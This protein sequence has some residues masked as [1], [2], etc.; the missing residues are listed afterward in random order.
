M[1]EWH[2]CPDAI[3]RALLH[4]GAPAQVHAVKLD[5]HHSRMA[6][7]PAACH[8]TCADEQH[9]AARLLV[10]ALQAYVSKVVAEGPGQQSRA[11]ALLA[12][13]SAPGAGEA[14]AALAIDPPSAAPAPAAGTGDGAGDGSDED[15]DQPVLD[16]Q[17]RGAA[18]LPAARRPAASAG[19]AALTLISL[20]HQVE[21][22]C[23]PEG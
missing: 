2:T 3:S 18:C 19:H 20:T 17:V 14:A 1:P 15:D 22:A 5:E 13:P 21:H 8:M 23:V 9:T 7:R 12:P 6:L 10:C 16:R 4:G 11:R